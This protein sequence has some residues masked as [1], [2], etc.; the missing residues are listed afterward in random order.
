MRLQAL[1]VLFVAQLGA[2]SA[3]T[4]VCP[5]DG[6]PFNYD[7]PLSEPLRGRDLDMRPVAGYRTPWPLPKC[8]ENGFIVYKNGGYSADEIAK[9][10][11]FVASERYQS[12][13][14]IHTGY[15]LA[16]VLRREAG[17][18][19]Y[20]VAWSLAEATWEVADD[21]ARYKAYAEEA[22][23]TFNSLPD[24]SRLDRRQNVLREM[25]SGELER[26]L[27]MFD[28]AEMRFR[29]IRDEAE[30]AAPQ[31]QHVIEF[32]LRLIKQKD[33]RSRRMPP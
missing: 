30:F 18:P 6:K 13:L 16:A 19:V 21:P 26:R 28:A 23:A 11:T 33:T 24:G 29:R 1:L 25:M 15:Y 8:P 32:Q 9:L 14:K 27:E 12:M 5:I 22:L 3:A 31:L 17:D 10:R 7:P 4:V 20:D 2:A